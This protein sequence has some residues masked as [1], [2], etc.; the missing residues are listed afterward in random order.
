MRAG[1]SGVAEVVKSVLYALIIC[2]I[3]ILV[4]SVILKEFEL[5]DGVLAPVAQVIKAVSI[6]LG[7]LF[8]MRERKNAAVRC[9]AAGALFGAVSIMLF[10]LITQ[11]NIMAMSSLVDIGLCAAAGLLCSIAVVIIKK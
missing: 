11:K 8:G 10:S 4:F 5:S 9:I 6:L 1:S 2:L 7:V 3:L